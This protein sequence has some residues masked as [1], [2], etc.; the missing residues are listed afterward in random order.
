MFDLVLFFY[1]NL[2]W[3]ALVGIA[4][5]AGG[6]ILIGG[7]MWGYYDTQIRGPVS[8]SLNF[9]VQC[10]ESPSK[11]YGF[12]GV[13]SE[14]PAE[15]PMSDEQRKMPVRIPV[16][17]F[18][19]KS[20]NENLSQIQTTTETG[21]TMVEEIHTRSP[22]CGNKAC[23]CEWH[24]RDFIIDNGEIYH[25]LPYLQFE[26]HGYVLTP[27]AGSA[28]FRQAVLISP[29]KIDSLRQIH[30]VLFFRGMPVMGRTTY[31]TIARCFE[32]D[33]ENEM[34]GGPAYIIT[35]SSWHIE[36]AQRLA[37][38]TPAYMVPN[39]D[40]I[41]SLY[42]MWGVERA[43]KLNQ[44]L[45]TAHD[46]INALQSQLNDFTGQVYKTAWTY[47]E[48]FFRTRQLPRMPGRGI[49]GRRGIIL[50]VLTAVTITLT[51]AY[52][53]HIIG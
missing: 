18:G 9:S 11:A 37:G 46:Q 19:R 34:F 27:A 51:I 20:A 39:S 32:M 52:L 31:I 13:W 12:W 33:P 44:Q 47:I 41:V 42:N 26:T 5:G 40:R 53:L 38:F 35:C 16:G 28:P 3:G 24:N 15:I 50:I 23:T 4:A 7:V 17:Y 22:A 21:L 49:L 43:M 48:S 10:F 8:S 29:C 14:P 36:L 1:V 2:T 25:R 30:D 45:T 6:G